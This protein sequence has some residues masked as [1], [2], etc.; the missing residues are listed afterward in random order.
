MAM[1]KIASV[2]DRVPRKS[3]AI[4]LQIG[5]GDSIGKV[6][7]A[8]WCSDDHIHLAMVNVKKLTVIDPSIYIRKRD[9]P[10]P[11]WVQECDH[12]KLV[13]LVSGTFPIQHPIGYLCVA[14]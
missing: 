6:K 5:A 7:S 8:S 1:P 3:S 4:W 9:M 11:K 13:W 2:A 10:R 14:R 12:Y